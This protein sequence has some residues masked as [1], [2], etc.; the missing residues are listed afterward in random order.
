MKA[1]TI[2]FFGIDGTGKTTLINALRER[3]LKEGINSNFVYMGVAKN[4]RIPFLKNIMN[5]Y[6][7]IRWCK[8]GNRTTYSAR[9]DT[10]RIRNFTWL[11]VYYLEL[12][13]KYLLSKKESKGRLILFDRYFFDGLFFAEG[14]NFR[15][16]KRLTPKPDICFLLKVPAEIIM[17]RKDEAK[18]EE[19]KRFYKKAKLISKYFPIRALDNTRELNKVVDEIM[20]YIK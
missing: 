18:E 20:V 2:A 12:W 4:Q 14:K 11:S 16:F 10:Y 17:Q 1:K 7:K 5:L 3:L 15:F 8:K 9:R 13:V 6:S 19:I